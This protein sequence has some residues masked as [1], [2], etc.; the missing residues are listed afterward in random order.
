MQITLEDIKESLR[1][2]CKGYTD[3][4]RYVTGDGHASAV[5]PRKNRGGLVMTAEQ[6][7]LSALIGNRL[8]TLGTFS[9]ED[10]AAV[11]YDEAAIAVFR[12]DA[13]TNFQVTGYMHLLG[14]SP[15]RL[16]RALG[17]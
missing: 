17:G 9:S 5:S 2:Q 14:A 11:A 10:A 6:A 15:S 7:S 8:T 3:Q 1:Q 12:L 16:A 4:G 13:R